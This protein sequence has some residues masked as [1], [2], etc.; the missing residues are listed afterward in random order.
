M[1]H[2]SGL[3]FINMAHPDIP[4]NL[5]SQLPHLLGKAV[6]SSQRHAW[7]QMREVSQ[8]NK[9]KVA[10]CHKGI[11]YSQSRPRTKKTHL[12]CHIFPHLGW[13]FSHYTRTH[14]SDWSLLLK[15]RFLLVK[16]PF[17]DRRRITLIKLRL[18]FSH[19]DFILTDRCNRGFTPPQINYRKS[20]SLLTEQVS[21]VSA[22][23]LHLIL[24]LNCVSFPHKHHFL[25]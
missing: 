16:Q 9:R 11:A 8:L 20:G 19:T 23:E 5:S 3:I 14:L 10:R 4:I 25:W 24:A 2:S 6:K 13:V 12:Q 22:S 18:L 7:E 1:I 17:C 15:W 21:R